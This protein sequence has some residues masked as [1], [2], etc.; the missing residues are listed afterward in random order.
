MNILQVISLH[1]I[2]E[3]LPNRQIACL[4]IRSFYASCAAL[5]EGLDVMRDMIAVVGNIEQKGSVVLAT[6]PPLKKKYHIKT[7][8]RLY[9]IPKDPKIYLIE[10]KVAT[11]LEIAMEIPRLLNQYVPIEAI[12]VYSVD[13][14]F[15]NL[16]GT[17]KLWGPVK[18]T[19]ERIQYD[20]LS[21]FQ[22]PSAVGVG[23]N[24]LMAKL[25]LDLEAKQSG[26][27]RWTYEDIQTKLWPIAPLSKMWG[28]GRRTE[29]TLN[30]MGIYS[31]GGLANSSLERL[32]KKFG[33]MGNQLYYHAWG[34]DLSELGGSQQ[35]DQMSYGKS[36]VL[37]RDYHTRKSILIVILEMC[38]D[39]A[40]RAR[41]A[42][43]VAY[44][45]NLGI[46]YAKHV[47]RSGF[48]RSRSIKEG[49]NETMDIYKVCVDLFDTFHNQKAVRNI[50][51]SITNLKAD[52]SMQLDL[53]EVDKWQKKKLATAID[54]IK[55]RF[56]ATAITRGVS[57]TEDGTAMKRSQ[58]V[59]G[60][61]R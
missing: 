49:T 30:H 22:L 10:S 46:G 7:G 21:Q 15:F 36:Q 32:E 24:M 3:G 37:M 19:I 38:E 58:L 11:Y 51:I 1:R 43:K 33:I 54:E 25:A 42:G 18:Q 29:H 34:V 48:N 17:E 4:D 57:L 20:L 13:E 60:H 44:T 27:A 56:G 31:V 12:H 14:C 23:P 52:T 16:A 40:M 35:Q 5:L 41:V 59:G 50:S 55:T 45:I 61:Q 9:E 2:Y 47:R 53:F 28:I 26:Y 6:S 39:I 8:N